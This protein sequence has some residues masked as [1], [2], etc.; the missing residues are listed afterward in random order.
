[1]ALLLGIYERLLTAISKFGPE[2]LKALRGGL[3]STREELGR[4][5]GAFLASLGIGAAFAI[6]VSARIMTG[7]LENHHDPTFGFFFGLVLA[8]IVIPYRLIRQFSARVVISGVVAAV[9]VVGLTLAMSGEDRL[10]A[11]R[12]KAAIKSRKVSELQLAENSRGNSVAATAAAVSPRVTTDPQTMG[13]FFIAGIIAICAMI[14]PGISGSFMLLLMGVYFDIL[15]CIN[16]RQILL[17]ACFA[18]G[19]TVGLLVFTRFLKYLLKQFHDTTMSFMLGLVIGS[20]YAIWPF[21]S[22]DFADGKRVDIANII[23][24]SLGQNEMLTIATIVAGAALV[25]I[26]MAIEKRLPAKPE[27]SC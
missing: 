10:E 1:M 7:L 16:E 8:S 26:F 13:L 11:A 27:K 21:K 6:V 18:A 14:L 23:P 22:F 20:L 24:A 17:L 19:A 4:L 25:L 5:D 15:I 9:L 3:Q 2:T 12:K